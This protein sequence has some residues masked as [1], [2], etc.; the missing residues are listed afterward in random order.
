[1]NRVISTF[2]RFTRSAH[3]L[4]RFERREPKLHPFDER[5]I[6]PSLPLDVRN[7]F[8]DGHY[9]QATFEACKYLDKV[10]QRLSNENISG[11][12]LMMKVFKEDSPILQITPLTTITE[13]DEQ[14]GYKFIFAG[15][16]LAIRNPRGHENISDDTETCLEHLSIVTH[17]LRRLEKAGY[18]LPDLSVT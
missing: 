5:D 3:K 2:E 10:V 18:E 6:H 14:E 13:K 4:A 1:M 16:V 7:L 17:L 8:D 15:S 11:K 9:A 12:S